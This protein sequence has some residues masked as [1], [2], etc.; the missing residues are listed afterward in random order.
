MEEDSQIKI[1]GSTDGGT[2]WIDIQVDV[3]GKL[4]V[5]V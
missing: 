4:M 2:T 5:T 1:Q 3:D